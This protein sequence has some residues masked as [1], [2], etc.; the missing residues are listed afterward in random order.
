MLATSSSLSNHGG[1]TT[2][3]FVYVKLGNNYGLYFYVYKGSDTLVLTNTSRNNSTYGTAGHWHKVTFDVNTKTV[4]WYSSSSTSKD[5]YSSA[6]THTYS[7]SDFDS[8][9]DPA[10]TQFY[11]HAA[12]RGGTDGVRNVTWV[13]T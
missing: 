4:S 1:S 11:I 8:L 5:D 2:G 10:T 12:G 3:K 7:Q 6:I 13:A 9:G